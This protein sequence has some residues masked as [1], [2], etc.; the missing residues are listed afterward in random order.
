MATALPPWLRG[1]DVTVFTVT[2]INE[3][4][5]GTLTDATGTGVQTVLLKFEEWDLDNTPI[6]EEMSSA[7][8]VG[9]HDMIIQ[10]RVEMTVQVIMQR[11]KGANETTNAKDNP[12]AFLATTYHVL[13]FDTTF[14]AHSWAF[15]GRR[16]PFNQSGRK[17]KSTERLR[18]T[19]VN[20]GPGVAN[21]TYT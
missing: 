21:P 15:T 14:G 11:A 17:G 4:S 19:P 9:Q 5:D 3:A 13:R 12:L 2:G 1:R 16:G 20:L 6:T 8:M 7:D 10:E 18:L